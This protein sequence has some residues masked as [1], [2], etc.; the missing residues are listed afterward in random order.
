MCAEPK[1]QSILEPVQVVDNQQVAPGVWVIVLYAPHVAARV[2]PGQFVHLRLMGFE[3]H[4]L[5]RPLSVYGADPSTGN[6]E[7][8]YQVVGS[9]TDWMTGLKQGTNL[10]VI[11][12]LGRGW[13]PPTDVRR[14]LLVSGGLGAAPLTMLAQQLL[15]QGAEVESIMG[16]PT[17]ERLVCRDRLHAEGT[18]HLSIATDD[19]SEGHGG[20]CTEILESRLIAMSY[21]GSHEEQFDYAAVCG[22]APMMRIACDLIIRFVPDL[23]C[24]LSLERQM[25]CGIGACLSCAVET[26]SGFRRSCKDGP[27]FDAR[28]VIW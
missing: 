28:E 26:T 13:H 1:D 11:G 15:S 24:E 6:I 14:V 9:G 7:L 8:M 23:C 17:A 5:R 27:V 22:P 12:P 3:A 21:G 20:Y 16:A 19:G 18:G 2:E 10:D 4:I 25:A